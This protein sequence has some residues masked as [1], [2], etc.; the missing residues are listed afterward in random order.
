MIIGVD[1]FDWQARAFDAWRRGDH[2]EADR[3]YAALLP[4]VVFMMQSIDH[5]VCYG[6]RIAALRLGLDVHDRAPALAPT[7]FG[8]EAARRFA[9][10]LGPL[11]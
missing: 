5:L 7:A 10:A 9:A 1:S 3:L 8:L 2:G 6:K 4:D 11:A